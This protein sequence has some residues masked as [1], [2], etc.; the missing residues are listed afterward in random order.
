[1]AKKDYEYQTLP[2]GQY[3][4]LLY[5]KKASDKAPL[6]AHLTTHCLRKELKIRPNLS[7]ALWRLRK[8]GILRVW[9]D[10]VCINQD[11]DKERTNQ[12]K[13]MVKIY[14]SATRVAVHL[15]EFEHYF[16]E[17]IGSL[18]DALSMFCYRARKG[19]MPKT[20][21]P[22]EY[23]L[24]GLPDILDPKWKYF[25]GGV[26]LVGTKIVV[27]N[28]YWHRAHLMNLLQFTEHDA[29]TD[30]RDHLFAL[31]GISKESNVL[32][33]QPDYQRTFPQTCLRV[34]TYMISNG[35]GPDI[36]RCVARQ[37]AGL[38]S[39]VPDWSYRRHLLPHK[40]RAMSGSQQVYCTAKKS[41][42]MFK[43]DEDRALVVNGR[44]FDRIERI[45][46]P[47]LALKA[48]LGYHF[49]Y[50]SGESKAEVLYRLGICDQWDESA[51]ALTDLLEHLRH[52]VDAERERI[53]PLAER[54]ERKHCEN[55]M[56]VAETLGPPL[57]AE[58]PLYEHYVVQAFSLFAAGSRGRT[59][60]GYICHVPYQAEIGDIISVIAG[61]D[62][63][64]LLRP[65]IK[66]GMYTL[67]GACYV[68][69]IMYGEQWSGNSSRTK[70]H[71][72]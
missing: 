21:D 14:E 41:E 18:F 42:Q 60:K 45:G 2:T 40:P 34:A 23:V 13:M 43:L 70:I 8:R 47:E 65:H 31:V 71:I 63:P 29:A 19:E 15:G 66:K 50:P 36:L 69:G 28:L 33:L 55:V 38:P 62:V 57:N 10:A 37:H 49:K 64:Y 6:Q 53:T 39:W 68:H 51:N 11:D 58:A 20:L 1:M 12:V 30:L 24:Y 5:L 61:C 59:D 4:R 56:L 46:N 48:E 44:L 52:W 9:A 22:R 72:I 7:S 27:Q 25:S 17:E 16:V 35:F 32:E 67:V 3:I 54:D 26:A